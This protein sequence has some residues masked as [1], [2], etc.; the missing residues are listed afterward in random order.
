MLRQERVEQRREELA[1]SWG[2]E[3]VKDVERAKGESL[4]VFSGERPPIAVLNW[5]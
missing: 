3:R 4:G 5:E 1:K 2:G